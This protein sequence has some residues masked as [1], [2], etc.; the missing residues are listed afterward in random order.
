MSF[1]G[2]SMHSQRQTFY[3]LVEEELEPET[4]PDGKTIR[5]FRSMVFGPYEYPEIRGQTQIRKAILRYLREEEGANLEN[6]TIR[7]K[8]AVSEST[9]AKINLMAGDME[10][11][12]PPVES[13]AGDG[14][15]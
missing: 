8:V 12:S 10:P 1:K 15:D 13:W 9:M 5:V 14:D 6:V 3:L 11:P 7:T 4:F 2:S